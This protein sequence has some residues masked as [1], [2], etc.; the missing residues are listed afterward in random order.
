MLDLKFL[1]TVDL[2]AQDILK[3][4][5]L[6][7]DAQSL[8]EERMSG[9]G[10]LLLELTKALATSPDIEARYNIF[11]VLPLGKR[12]K[13]REHNI[14]GC[15][16]KT[17]FLPARVIRVLNRLKIM[18]PVDILTG[19]GI[20]LFPN[21][22]NFPVLFS[23]SLTYI[24]DASFLLYPETV[25]PKNLKYLQ[26]N[27]KTWASRTD[28]ILTLTETSKDDLSRHL[29]LDTGKIDVIPCGVDTTKYYRRSIAQINGVKKKYGIL[30][31]DYILY[32]GNLEPRKN[33]KTLL[34]AYSE[35]DEV[36]KDKYALVIV[37]A[38]AWLNDD[39]SKLI[40]TLRER[41]CNIIQPDKFVLDEDLPSIYSGATVYV[42]PA[43]YEGFG[44]PPIEA[45]ACGVP[46]LASEIP[47]FTE[48]LKSAALMFDPQDPKDIT[49][50]LQAMLT[51]KDLQKKYSREGSGLVQNYSWHNSV[52]ALIAAID[53]T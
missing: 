36:I 3:K 53:L 20:Y 38:G 33:L 8:A 7:I 2:E 24:H 25:E 13:V 31:Q 45:M 29:D 1:L 21:Y 30:A 44:M 37:G 18:P 5:N 19:T 50:A 39:T 14:P 51:S 11:L 42:H 10:H 12:K 16:F 43:I 23:K 15:K 40:E 17:I 32:V 49:R 52:R 41:G 26:S 46:V 28:R 22:R 35:M 6:L 9:I 48:V 47:V 4:K 34:L 27:V